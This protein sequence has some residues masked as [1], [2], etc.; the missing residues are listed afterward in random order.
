MKN[1]T[2]RVFIDTN[3]WFSAFYGSPN[4]LQIVEFHKDGKIKAFVSQKILQEL[5]KNIKLKLPRAFQLLE[6]LLLNAPPE[7][8]SDPPSLD[9]R[10]INLIDIKDQK[11]FCSA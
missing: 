9:K 5:T 11:I 4:C 10:I 2:P 6:T 8:V 3:V 1:K 7:I